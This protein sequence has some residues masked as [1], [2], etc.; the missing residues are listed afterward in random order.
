[1]HKQCTIYNIQAGST[2]LDKKKMQSHV[3]FFLL[4]SFYNFLSLVPLLNIPTVSKYHNFCS[5]TTKK[6]HYF[7]HTL[8]QI[9]VAGM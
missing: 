2:I 8:K 7:K 1:M 6:Q 9:L 4:H 3:Q 5:E